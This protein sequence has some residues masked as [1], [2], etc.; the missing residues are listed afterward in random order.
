MPFD[1]RWHE[2]DN[3]R[4]RDIVNAGP[5]LP[6]TRPG[7]VNE[8][9]D[10]RPGPD[11][12]DKAADSGSTAGDKAQGGQQ[13][14]PG[15]RVVLIELATEDAEAFIRSVAENSMVIVYDRETEAETVVEASVQ[16]VVARPTVWCKCDVPVE[17]RGARR[18]RLAR[19]ESSWTRGR[20]FGWWL[21]SHCRK[22]SRAVVMH[23]VTTMLAGA[24]DLLPQILGEGEPKPPTERWVDEG[25]VPNPFVNGNSEHI[26]STTERRRPRKAR[27]PHPR[28]ESASVA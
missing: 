13:K 10:A 3:V 26:R 11:L 4:L 22:P 28:R 17:S 19:R 12:K 20:Q 1:R 23:W 8:P 24:N 15:R 16:A 27:T 2:F 14:L 21:C 18:K 25:G 6:R 9:E 7:Q 5:D